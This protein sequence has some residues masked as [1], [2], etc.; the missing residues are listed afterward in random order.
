SCMQAYSPSCNKIFSFY[1]KSL[2]SILTKAGCEDNNIFSP[3]AIL[4]ILATASPFE[5]CYPDKD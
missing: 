4:G 5:S 1:S 2:L 3:S